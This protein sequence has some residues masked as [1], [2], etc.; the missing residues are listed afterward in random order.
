MNPTLIALGLGTA[1]GF[2]VLSTR[3]PATTTPTPTTPTPTTPPDTTSTDPAKPD[4]MKPD[5]TTDPVD[6]V[7]KPNQYGCTPVSISLPDSAINRARA[8]LDLEP[9]PKDQR[10]QATLTSVREMRDLADAIAYC[11]S[12]LSAGDTL[13]DSWVTALHNHATA[14]EKILKPQ[15]L[16]AG[17]GWGYPSTGQEALP[18][19]AQAMLNQFEDA[20]AKGRS[21]KILT[22]LWNAYNAARAA[23]GLPQL[24]AEIFSTERSDVTAEVLGWVTNTLQSFTW[25][26]AI[27]EQFA[28]EVIRQV[29]WLA[30]QP[31]TLNSRRALAAALRGQSA[32]QTRFASSRGRPFATAPLLSQAADRLEAAAQYNRLGHATA[33]PPI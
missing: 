27:N 12:A 32:A 23:A 24:P 21:G 28:Y 16:T 25:G 2:L 26:D 10:Y 31:M 22:A 6:P 20:R 5:P 19:A 30:T 1:V 17:Y 9:T 33:R 18:P 8:L 3:R 4:P 29:D 13:R 11:G 14:V 7:P 15:G